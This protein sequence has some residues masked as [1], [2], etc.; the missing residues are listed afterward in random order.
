MKIAIIKE[1]S[2]LDTGFKSIVFPQKNQTK[3]ITLLQNYRN[4]EIN[5]TKFS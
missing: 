4:N 1:N 2:T 3:N 5:C